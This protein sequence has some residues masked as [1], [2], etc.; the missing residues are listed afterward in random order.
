MHAC[1]SS[2]GIVRPI[3]VIVKARRNKAV[4]LI[5]GIEPFLLSP[6]AIADALRARCQ[7][8]TS[9]TSILT[10]PFNGPSDHESV[11]ILFRRI[12]ILSMQ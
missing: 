6:T 9:G 12:A 7:S 4:T 11:R 1:A 5:M 3:S 10:C 8:S 2:K